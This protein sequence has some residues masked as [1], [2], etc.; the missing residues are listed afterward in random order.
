MSNPVLS[1]EELKTVMT[2][3][4][5]RKDARYEV[6]RQEA[7]DA[8]AAGHKVSFTR[9]SGQVDEEYEDELKN[10]RKEQQRTNRVEKGPQ[11]RK[12][13][14]RTQEQKDN[15]NEKDRLKRMQSK[16][17]GTWVSKASVNMKTAR[18]IQ[19]TGRMRLTYY[20]GDI[21]KSKDI[22]TNIKTAEQVDNELREWAKER[23]INITN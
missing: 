22:R 2:D 20:E 7:H 16:L 1:R 8:R 21:R 5:K 13:R 9:L 12:A 11:P 15:R 23:S 4:S 6:L 3:I 14:I 17:D 18:I 10:Y 19:H